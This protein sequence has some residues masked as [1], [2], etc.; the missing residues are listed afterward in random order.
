[1]ETFTVQAMYEKGVLKPKKKLNLPERTIV[2]VRVTS[3]RKSTKPTAFASL[4]GVWENMPTK[5]YNAL[6]KSL[7]RARKKSS[8]KV[9]RLAK[10]IK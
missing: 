6:E 4:M 3:I 10:I 9:K 2:Q 8:T 7:T 1:M 5:K